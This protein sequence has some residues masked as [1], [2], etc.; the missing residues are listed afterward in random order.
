MDFSKGFNY[1][2]DNI[3]FEDKNYDLNFVEENGIL[4]FDYE[5]SDKINFYGNLL[6]LFESLYSIFTNPNYEISSKCAET[7]N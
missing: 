2:T 1:I 4:L 7:N 3:I 5:Y 6:R